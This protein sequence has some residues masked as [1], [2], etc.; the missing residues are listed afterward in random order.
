MSALAMILT[1]AL[2]VPGDGPEKVL[3]DVERLPQPLDLR[4]KWKGTISKYDRKYGEF[5]AK[6]Y[7]SGGRLKVE[8]NAKPGEFVADVQACFVDEGNGK[9]RF[10]LNG[11]QLYLGIYR[12]EGDR[13]IG[14]IGHKDRPSEF[15]L[16]E[17]RALISLHRV[18]SRK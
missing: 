18:N 10:R 6:V 9:F 5:G 17:R 11:D 13:F 1:A 16:A 2:V 8:D 15:K 3:G 12:Q 4:G 14:C 7:F